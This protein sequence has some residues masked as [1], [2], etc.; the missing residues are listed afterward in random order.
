M[1]GEV[2][3]I[4]SQILSRSGG[5]MGIS[6]SIPIDDAMKVADQLRS[7]GKVVRGRI[8]VQIE[9]ITKD[10]AES[11]GLDKP[12]GA[13]V[14]M[15]EPG[16]P[17][18]KAGIEAGDVITRF[19]GQLVDKAGDLPR[20]VGASKPGSK[21]TVQVFRRGAYKDLS[22]VVVELDAPKTAEKSGKDT[23]PQ[24]GL[25]RSALGLELVDLTAEQK[26]ELKVTAGVGVQDVDG[27]AEAAGLRAGD[28]ILALAN[29]QVA[30]V[31]QFESVLARLDRSRPVSVLVR[32]GDWAQYAVIRPTK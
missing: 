4:N 18:D 19:N 7:G 11:L 24:A 2:V 9:P 32:R 12:Q 30:D 26:R 1:R 5:F 29:A 21:G 16:G 6:F 23:K 20:L 31:R 22:V 10:V 8:G 25:S 27:P 28:V 15:V 3:G 13:V 14:R 17:A